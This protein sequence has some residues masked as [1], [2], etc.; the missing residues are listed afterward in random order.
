MILNNMHVALSYQHVCT[1][2][3]CLGCVY[4]GVC[5]DITMY[6]ARAFLLCAEREGSGYFP[7]D[8]YV[9]LLTHLLLYNLGPVIGIFFRSQLVG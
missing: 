9:R 5:D 8:M 1:S 2:L 7:S 3:N 6:V 4:V